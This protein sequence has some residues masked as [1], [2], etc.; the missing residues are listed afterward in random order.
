MITWLLC[1]AL[2][3]SEES[4]ALRADRLFKEGKFPESA[5]AFDALP[6]SPEVAFNRGCALLQARDF[7]AAAEAFRLAADAPTAIGARARFN[8]GH[9]L[10]GLATQHPQEESNHGSVP[11]EPQA[12]LEE[13][14]R[15]AAAFRSVLEI[16]P[17]D[18]EAARNTEIVR[19]MIRQLE[20]QMK[21]AQEQR[22]K[23]QEQAD[24][25]DH[26]ADQ[27][28]KLADQA[29]QSPPSQTEQ[30]RQEQEQLNEQTGQAM[31]E[32]AEQLG[33]RPEAGEAARH[34][35]EAMNEQ[36]ESMQDLDERRP[37][38]A[39][40]DMQQAADKLREAAR[41]LRDAAKQSQ[42]QQQKQ[43]QDQAGQDQPSP[44]Q[45]PTQTQEQP[46]SEEEKVAEQILQ[47]EQ[48]QREAR[49]RV[50][51]MYAVPIPVE[52]DW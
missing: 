40:E 2:A 22:Q 51:R 52:K 26:L 18:T 43:P 17:S 33:A 3:Q 11:P 39:A 34:M 9:A 16:D 13:L 45:R 36:Q 37:D 44:E 20:E 28:Q 42:D 50:R 12:A 24:K 15:A 49:E 46:K 38:H 7:E 23:L 6:E 19:R 35:Q 31:R 10:L 8:L 5:A 48:A 29:R 1:I 41:K 21:Q 27:Q 30:R 25:L 47:A 4:L 32:M 14:R